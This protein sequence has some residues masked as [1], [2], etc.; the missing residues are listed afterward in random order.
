MTDSRIPADLPDHIQ[1]YID[2]A[3]D[4]SLDGDT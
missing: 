1:H 4:D 2:G 3:Y